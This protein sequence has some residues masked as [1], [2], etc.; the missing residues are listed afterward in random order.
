MD[1]A[2][3]VHQR[4][5]HWIVV[6]LAGCHDPCPPRLPGYLFHSQPR[7]RWGVE[8]LAAQG[9]FYLVVSPPVYVR[10]CISP[11]L[12]V[13]VHVAELKHMH[14]CRVSAL[15]AC[16]LTAAVLLGF[17]HAL[18]G[19]SW[20]TGRSSPEPCCG[21][22]WRSRDAHESADSRP[23]ASQQQQ[24]CEHIA[25]R[26]LTKQGSNLNPAACRGPPVRS[27]PAPCIDAD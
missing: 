2:D 23:A 20:Q 26:W 14:A 7:H 12:C 18:H 22:A 13:T 3:L 17:H 9:A 24:S 8:L 4:R 16:T 1:P 6:Y 27:P 19:T 15:R 25:P 10:L 5:Q 11:S 21:P